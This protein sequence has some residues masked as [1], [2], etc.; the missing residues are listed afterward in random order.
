VIAV[1]RRARA[2]VL[3]VAG[4]VAAACGPPG[5]VGAHA[6]PSVSPAGP[7]FTYVAIGASE[8]FGLGASDPARDA[9]PQVFYRN[10]LPRAVTLVDLGIPGATVEDAIRIELPRERRVHP[11]L[12]TVWLN[13]N[14]IT[15]GVPLDTYRSQLTQLLLALR[16]GGRT[17]VLVANT[18]PL[19]RL[20]RLLECQPYAPS[21]HGCD[22]TRRLPLPEVVRVV[23][24]FNDAIA[25]VVSAT[26]SV[27]VDLHAWGESARSPAD[28]R[29]F[30][31]S[32]GFHPS[33]AGYRSI[34]DVFARAYRQS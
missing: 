3:A 6:V 12:V 26:G 15:H 14:D 34:A 2:V 7:A 28:I 22:H 31:G 5:Q 30:V 24:E 27:L 21:D 10:V 8:S 23:D 20:P 29:R 16:D 33:S 13:V 32:D 1:G 19:D 17:T 9:W 11:K 4:L 18:P 25:S